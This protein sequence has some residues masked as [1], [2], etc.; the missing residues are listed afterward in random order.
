[1]APHGV[2][3]RGTLVTKFGVLDDSSR[4]VLYKGLI[5]TIGPGGL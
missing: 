1:M 3:V 5:A 2:M 4:G